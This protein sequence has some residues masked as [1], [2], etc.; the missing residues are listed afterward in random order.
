MR[1]RHGGNLRCRRR[2][3]VAEAGDGEGSVEVL[4]DLGN[5]PIS[6]GPGVDPRD[7]AAVIAALNDDG[8]AEGGDRLRNES[9]GVRGRFSSEHAHQKLVGRR[10]MEPPLEIRCDDLDDGVGVARA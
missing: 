6:D 3:G 2:A 1:V 9:E 5:Y 4:P 7:R 10:T 8:G